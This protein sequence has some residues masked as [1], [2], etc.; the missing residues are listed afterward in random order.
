MIVEDRF[1]STL[2]VYDRHH[3]RMETV[4][5]R[6]VYQFMHTPWPECRLQ[7]IIVCYCYPE[8]RD[9]ECQRNEEVEDCNHGCYD[10]L[11][12]WESERWHLLT[13]GWGRAPQLLHPQPMID[14]QSAAI[15]DLAC[16]DCGIAQLIYSEWTMRFGWFSLT[17]ATCSCGLLLWCWCVFLTVPYFRGLYPSAVLQ[18][19][20]LYIH[21]RISYVLIVHFVRIA[22]IYQSVVYV[23]ALNAAGDS[24]SVADVT[25]LPAGLPSTTFPCLV[26]GPGLVPDVC[27]IKLAHHIWDCTHIQATCTLRTKPS[28]EFLGCFTSTLETGAW[29]DLKWVVDWGRRYSFVHVWNNWTTVD[30]AGMYVYARLT[31]QATLQRKLLADR[32]SRRSFACMM[33]AICFTTVIEFLPT[34][35]QSCHLL[36]W[37]TWILCIG[38]TTLGRARGSGTPWWRFPL[39]PVCISNTINSARGTQVLRVGP[40]L[41]PWWGVLPWGG[42][43]EGEIRQLLPIC[44]TTEKEHLQLASLLVLSNSL[45]LKVQHQFTPIWLKWL[46]I[47]RT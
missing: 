8:K 11:Y 43:L 45:R 3:A 27:N 2:K 34:P 31:W 38:V 14:F 44:K 30:I 19:C 10:V 9:W 15:T 1:D 13:W 40:L 25:A 18:V 4:V 23:S 36:H 32:G 20:T 33:R 21:V 47:W 17:V 41:Q 16:E 42:A 24:L 7:Q 12:R 35:L 28:R 39:R 46:K 37:G 29:L 5:C 22:I 6:V 26:C